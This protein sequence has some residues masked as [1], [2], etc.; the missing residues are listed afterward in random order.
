MFR[1]GTSHVYPPFKNGRYMEEYAYETLVAKQDEIKTDL[2]YLPIFWTNLQN[3]PGFAQ[4]RAKYDIVLNQVLQTFP[5]NTRFFTIVQ[6]DDGPQLQLPKNTIIFGACTGTIPLPLIYEDKTNR[7]SQLERKE[8]ELFASFVGSLTHPVR[9]R[10]ASAVES[11]PYIVCRM[12][13][14]WNVKVP[15]EQADEFLDLTLRSKFCLAPRGYGRSSFRFFEAILMDTIPVY[16]WDDVEWLP[17]KEHLDYTLFSVSISD[18]SK[19]YDILSGI[20]EERYQ[21]MKTELQKVKH[22]FTL[23]GMMEYVIEKIQ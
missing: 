17:Y 1:P 15:M 2:V 7:L 19:T 10:M 13:K 21:T 20:S 14:A 22:W 23:E 11:K 6:H 18:I 5:K 4:S 12:Q 9:Q 8:P 3:H 16:F